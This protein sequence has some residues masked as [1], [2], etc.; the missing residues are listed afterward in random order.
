VTDVKSSEERA[1]FTLFVK[2]ILNTSNAKDKNINVAVPYIKK[3]ME[4]CKQRQG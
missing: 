2:K 1:G 4:G 3:Y